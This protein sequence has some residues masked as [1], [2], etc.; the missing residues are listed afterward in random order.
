MYLGEFIF[1]SFWF[2]YLFSFLCIKYF[3]LG[4]DMSN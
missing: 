3:E 4:V 2:M 1:V